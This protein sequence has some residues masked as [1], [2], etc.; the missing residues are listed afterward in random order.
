MRPTAIRRSLLAAA[1]TAGVASAAKPAPIPIARVAYVDGLVEL[2]SGKSAW[3]RVAEG[4]ELRIGDRLRTGEAGSARVDFPWMSVALS[5]ASTLAVPDSLVLATVLE[6]GRLEQS[7]PSGDLIKL[8]A[9][10]ARIRGEGKVVVRREGNATFVSALAGR[11][12]VESAG[13]F[14]SVTGG[15]GTI[16]RG[17]ATPQPPRPLAAAPSDLDP[18]DDPRYTLPTESLTLRFR[19]TAR[20]HHVQILG[21]ESTQALIERDVQGIE[22]TLAIPWPGTFRWRV[23]A[24][25]GDGLEGLYSREGLIAVVEK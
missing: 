21:I 3:T 13:S 6:E 23:A 18:G 17:N 2:Q 19:S 24:R 5:G 20:H 4:G 16:V 15:E 7:A 14:V 11:F 10:P 9:G 12:R 22:V 1:L 8:I 25:D